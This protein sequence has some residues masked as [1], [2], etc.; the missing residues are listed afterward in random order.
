MQRLSDEQII[1]NKDV[2]EKLVQ[3]FP[4]PRREAVQKML[5]GPLGEEFFT[6]P[7]SSRE[8]YHSAYPGGLCE[9]SLR[10]VKNIRNLARTLCPDRYELSTLDCVALF[11]DL[12]KAGDGDEPF[13]VPN[14]NEWGRKRGFIYEINKKCVNMPT[15]ERTMYLMQRFNVLLTSEE[16]LAIRL[17]DGQYVE[18]NKRYAMVEPDLAL[19]LH[20]ADRWT[21]SQEKA[22]S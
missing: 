18:S 16:Y 12:G 19:L 4:S 13:Y 11:H 10:V 14:D 22:T 21:C 17:S 3:S 7:A 6:A 8:D 1:K 9:H 20:W 5:S 2:V 15:E